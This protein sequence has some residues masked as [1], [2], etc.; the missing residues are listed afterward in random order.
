MDS[1]DTDQLMLW[2][3]HC[4]IDQAQ[5]NELSVYGLRS[6]Y[7]FDTFFCHFYVA[8]FQPRI[9]TQFINVTID[10]FKKM[11]DS[12]ASFLVKHKHM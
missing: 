7:V 10:L 11:C 4:I 2:C 9:R 3:E 12:T 1:F 6:Y 5:T 8:E